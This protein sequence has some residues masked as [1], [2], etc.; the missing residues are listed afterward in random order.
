MPEEKLKLIGDNIAD[1]YGP[2][3]FVFLSANIDKMQVL[4]VEQVKMYNMGG[5]IIQMSLEI[6]LLQRAKTTTIA[7]VFI[8]NIHLSSQTF[9]PTDLLPVVRSICY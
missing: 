3:R 8:S 4:T 1:L 6:S 5:V 9:K 2:I 7:T